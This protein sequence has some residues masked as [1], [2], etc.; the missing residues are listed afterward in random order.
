MRAAAAEVAVE[1]F[2]DLAAGRRWIS[3]QQRCGAHQDAGDTIAALQR[4]LGDE[5]ALQRVWLFG[6]AKALDGG[7]VLVRHRPQR[8]VAGR[9]RAVADD[10]VT[11][12][13][14]AGAAA[15]MRPGHAK[16]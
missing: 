8:R 3:L 16:L 11:G 12:A 2:P 14:L 9:H 1:R 13:A 6:G 15:E 10:D 4:L 5:R 7:D